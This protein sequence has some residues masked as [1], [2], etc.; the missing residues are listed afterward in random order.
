MGDV[1]FMTFLRLQCDNRAICYIKIIPIFFD[2]DDFNE[3]PGYALFDILTSI[4][5]LIPLTTIYLIP[6]TAGF[7]LD[8]AADLNLEGFVTLQHVNRNSH[9]ARSTQTQLVRD[10][11]LCASIV[12]GTQWTARVCPT[13]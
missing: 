12:T 11:G 1:I 10:A 4:R 3:Q 5:T 8:L 13:E 2:R 6:D 9:T 7:G